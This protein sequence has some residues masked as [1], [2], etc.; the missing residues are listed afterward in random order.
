MPVEPKQLQSGATPGSPGEP[1]RNIHRAPGA[2]APQASAAPAPRPPRP[3]KKKKRGGRAWMAFRNSRP[4]KGLGHLLYTLGFSGE[5][6]CI[7]IWRVLR[8]AG[9]LAAQLLVWLFSRLGQGIVRVLRGVLH[10][11]AYPFTR[12]RRRRRQLRRLRERERRRSRQQGSA[13]GISYTGAGLKHRVSFLVGVVVSVLPVVALAAL[14]FTVYNVLG[15]QYALAVEVDGE[16]LGY[17]ADKSVVEN[18]KTL[19]RD[20]IRL[21]EDQKLSDW[22]FNP[23]YTLSRAVSFTTSQQLVN[24]ILLHSTDDRSNLVSATGIYINDHLF[25]VTDEGEA[26]K[27]YLDE[28]LE[29]YR[30]P[31]H[32]EAEVSFVD[33]VVCELNPD[34]VFLAS[35]MQNAESLVAE[36]ERVVS[37]EVTYQAQAGDTLARI[38]YRNGLTLDTLLAR[39]PKYAEEESDF[40]P[41]VGTQF[42]IERAQPFLQV[43]ASVRVSS[44]ESIPYR[45]IEQ[46]TDRRQVGRRDVVQEGAAGSQMVW[47]DLY[48]IDGELARSVRVDEMTQVIEAAVNEIV[49]V[50]TFDFN[51]AVITGEY[52]DVFMFP[53]PDSEWSYR[54][55]APG[56]RGVDLNGDFG[57]PIY[58]SNAGVVSY[59]GYHWSWGNNIVID[60]PNGI[61]TRYAHC[62]ELLVDV[63]EVVMQG[64]LIATLGSTGVSTGPHL[65]FEVMVDGVEQDP[66]NYVTFPEGY[67]ASWYRG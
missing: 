34:D 27:Q 62:T 45:V 36:L 22:Q 59:S 41:R 25:A 19:L 2:P 30:D 4:V 49:E 7:K 29:S 37:D 51:T 13:P 63:G 56:H 32:P 24:A 44:V 46:E 21:A 12:Y 16:V 1:Q 38:A 55:K 43:Q 15:V 57:I 67:R 20:R 6:I 42:L 8:E 14:A 17:V 58:A 3:A 26:V 31:A 18:A 50:G 40:E 39:N 53:V 33:Q 66:M 48:Y 52:N 28:K 11:I 54:G 61:Q 35:A 10:D 65:H 60:H 23:D 5:Y 64:D 9:T 47:D